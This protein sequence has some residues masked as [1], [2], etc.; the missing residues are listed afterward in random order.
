MNNTLDNCENYKSLYATNS[1]FQRYVDR[2]KN[3]F[4]LSLDMALSH[5]IVKETAHYYI[6]TEKN[7]ASKE[8]QNINIELEDKS[9]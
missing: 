1:D 2:Y 3:E 7:K 5:A 9:C 4:N 8:K 6:K